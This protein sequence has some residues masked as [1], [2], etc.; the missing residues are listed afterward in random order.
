MSAQLVISDKTAGRE[1]LRLPLP[2]SVLLLHD[3]GGPAAGVEDAHLALASGETGIWGILTA[4]TSVRARVSGRP[5]V[6]RMVD[7]SG[8][9]L[10]LDG[11]VYE[12]RRPAAGVRVA[13]AEEDGH[14]PVCGL[15]MRAGETILVCSAGLRTCSRFCA[16]GGSR[17]EMCPCCGEALPAEEETSHGHPRD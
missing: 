7:L 9:P 5:V 15:A 1:L 2:K 8:R 16:A 17:D 12:I 13:V 3:D 4:G 11:H 6:G 10:T 14:C